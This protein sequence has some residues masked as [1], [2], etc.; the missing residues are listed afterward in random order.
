MEVN[1]TLLVVDPD[2]ND[3]KP[4]EKYIGTLRIMF[5]GKI[6]RVVR[7]HGEL[8]VFDHKT[9]SMGGPNFFSEFYTAMQFRGYKWALE[10]IMGESVSG[11]IVNGIICR[12]PVK[13][14]GRVNYDMDRH[15][16]PISDEHRDEWMN[17]YLLGVR[18]WLDCIINQINFP[19]APEQAFP[20]RTGSCFAKYGTCEFYDVCC[21][22]TSQRASMLSTG[23][24]EDHS[25]S[26]LD[27][28]AKPKEKP[29]PMEF[30]GLFDHLG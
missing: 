12:P 15:V 6:D 21:L 8:Y 28:N 1:A 23:L 4:F 14:D 18:E 2:E 13:S 5:T 3:G 26:P 10:Q 30:G 20:I 22:P 9:S 17:S 19:D 16:I 25:W 11:V 27:D 29:E 7:Y 24:F